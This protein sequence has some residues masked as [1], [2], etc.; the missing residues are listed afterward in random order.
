MAIL[1]LLLKSFKNVIFGDPFREGFLEKVETQ[2]NVKIFVSLMLNDI[3][4]K[5]K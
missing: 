3:T 2:Y 4:K 1:A 5:K